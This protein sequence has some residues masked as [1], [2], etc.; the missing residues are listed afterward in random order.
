M[1]YEVSKFGNGVLVGS[2]GNVV[3]TV[4][5]RFNTQK[6]GE[7]IG[8][9]H[10][11]DGTTQVT[12]TITGDQLVRDVATG[13]GFIKALVLPVG[14][15]LSNVVVQVKEAFAVGGTTPT[16]NV[17]TQG[18]ETTNGFPI[19]EAQAEAVGTYKPTLAGTWA[20]PLAAAVT[21]GVALGGTSPTITSA[22]KMDIIFEYI[23]A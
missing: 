10:S 11:Q 13:D 6:V 2:G 5:T 21:V 20:S 12:M 23:K 8:V 17:G 15:V 1:T 14:A 22:G 19:S 3:E 7:Q 16:I 9:N 18:S 4:H